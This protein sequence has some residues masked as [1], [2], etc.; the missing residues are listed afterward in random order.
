MIVMIVIVMIVIKDL[1][2]SAAESPTAEHCKVVYGVSAV[3]LNCHGG[4]HSQPSGGLVAGYA[5]GFVGT[6][7]CKFTYICDVGLGVVLVWRCPLANDG[8]DGEI[9]FLL[10]FSAVLWGKA[11][12]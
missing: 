7:A 2:I 4:A 11:M 5:D 1:A 6:Y 12:L 3:L 8:A 10:M 9:F